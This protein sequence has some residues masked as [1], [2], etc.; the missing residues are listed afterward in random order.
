MAV[1]LLEDGRRFATLDAINPLI[2]PTRVDAFALPVGVD[3][4]LAEPALDEAGR[5]EVL[6]HRNPALDA[7][8][9]SAGWPAPL[10]QVFW[11]SMPKELD[12]LIDSYGPPHV[13]PADEVHHVVDGAIEFGLV[14]GDGSQ[15]LL[16][17]LPGDALRLHEGTE[18]WSVL[19]ADR[20]AKVVVHLSRP[21]GFSHRFTGT[22]VR[23]R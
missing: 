9:A 17:L 8:T 20:R 5:A 1:L 15:A 16:T 3:H 22:E 14:L 4:L 11:P 2:G 7:E 10:L 6:G 13:N 21:P 18:H 12:D 19:T 23:I